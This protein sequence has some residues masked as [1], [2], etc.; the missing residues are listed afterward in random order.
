MSKPQRGL[1]PLISAAWDN[2][3]DPVLEMH[4]TR[5]IVPYGPEAIP[6]LDEAD[7]E[8]LGVKIRTP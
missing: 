4:L 8:H 1:G 7:L 3:D 6:L 5:A 2:D